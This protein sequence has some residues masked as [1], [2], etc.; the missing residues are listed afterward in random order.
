MT[1]S[2]SLSFIDL[3]AGIGGFHQAFSA[4]GAS[5]VFASEW[6]LHA[7]SVYLRNYG[8]EPHGDITKIAEGEIPS[9]D[10]LCGGFPCQAFSISGKR[11]GFNDTRGTLFF[12]IARIIRHHKPRVLLLEN[13]KNFATHD[14]GTTLKV[15]LQTL[16]DLGYQVCY[17]V[18]NSGNYGSAQKRE[19]IYIVGIRHDVQNSF[20]FPEELDSFKVVSDI[21][22][23][24]GDPSL[25]KLIIAR[26]DI[27]LNLNTAV[28]ARVRDTVRVG[29]V[30]KGG[31]G[32]RIY[33]PNGQAITLSAYGG[34]VGAKT[35]LYLIEGVVRR[36]SPRECARLQGFPDSFILHENQNQAYKQFGNSV[37]VP[38]VEKLAKELLR[39]LS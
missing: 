35:G 34:G 4:A 36:L 18:L 32:E 25:T 28:I 12:E 13:V 24:A 31:Q 23:P 21:L 20:I 38:V 7:K 37:A 6:D 10:I 29:I 15:V 1:S 11:Q 16:E 39:C 19:R 26:P 22:V 3:F 5:C 2:S 8:I 27:A 17:K 14:N 9:H 33:H 30:N